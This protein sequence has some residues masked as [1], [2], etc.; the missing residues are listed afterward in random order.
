M[1]NINPEQMQQA[2][3]QMMNNPMMQNVMNDPEMLRNMFSSNPAI[4][5]VN[6]CFWGGPDSALHVPARQVY[7]QLCAL[8][9]LQLMDRNPEFAQVLNNPQQL[10]E[11]MQAA[12]NPVSYTVTVYWCIWPCIQAAVHHSLVL[13]GMFMV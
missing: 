13:P 6:K 1:G 7:Q 10:Q 12:T 8:S 11:A 4:Q 9:C 3:S 5:Q 2:M